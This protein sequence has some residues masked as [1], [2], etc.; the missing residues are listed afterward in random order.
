MRILIVNILFL[1]LSTNSVYATGNT[2]NVEVV[3]AQQQVRNVELSLSGNVKALNDAQLASQESG[4]VNHIHVDAGDTVKAGQVLMEL[5]DSLAVIELAQAQAQAT[6]ANIKYQEDLRLYNEIVG[7]AKREVIAKTLLAQRKSNVAN[8]QAMLNQANATVK[9]QQAVVSRHQ[10]VAPFAGTIAVRNVD[11]G[12]WVSPQSQ[13][14]QLVSDQS[15]RIFVDIPQ[16]HFGDIKTTNSIA[17]RVTSDF[18]LEA[19]SLS[20]SQFNRVSDPA[21]RTFKGRIDLPEN[22][23]FVSG[24]SVKVSLIL[25]THNASQVTLPKGTL[26]RHPDGSYSV[27][28]VVNG[29]VK[30]IGIRLLSSSFD[31]VLVQ[32][33]PDNSA[34]IT[35][36]TDLLIENMSVTIVDKKGA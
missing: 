34:I 13:V 28:S 14:L 15:L 19:M 18:S 17:A 25:P 4:I 36:G 31:E 32:G 22:T 21:S 10:L 11:L 27:Y 3:Y 9:R 26:K 29:V 12:E 23:I 6:S 16:E 33:V 24:M 30:R 5:D 20:L 35:S 8:S 7:L 1:L 2:T